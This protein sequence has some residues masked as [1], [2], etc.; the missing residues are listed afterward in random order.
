MYTVYVACSDEYRVPLVGAIQAQPNVIL[1]GQASDGQTAYDHCAR[2]QPGVLILDDA[3]LIQAS[4]ELMTQF[5][6]A[7]YPIVVLAHTEGPQTAKTA[8][9]V[10]ADDFLDKANWKSE[11]FG[12]LDRVA[13][14]LFD[15]NKAGKLISIFSSKGGVGKTTLSVNLALALAQKLHDPVV[16]VDLDLNAGDV[17]AMVGHPHPSHTVHDLVDGPLDAPRVRLALLEVAPNLYV[18][19]APEEVQDVDDIEPHLLISLLSLLKDLFSYVVVDLAPG[20]DDVIVTTLDLSD[21]ILA[22]CTPDVVT[23]RTVAQALQLLRD[24]FHYPLAKVRLVLNRSGSKTGISSADV[25]AILNN[26]VAYEL[27]SEGIIPARAANEGIPLLLSDPRC[28][29]A[30]AI[31]NLATTLIRESEATRTRRRNPTRT[32]WLGRLRNKHPKHPQPE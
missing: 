20:Y 18:L 5:A 29:L 25:K 6:Q 30:G 2:I 31:L 17:A 9:A 1:A 15:E 19:A 7:P 10:G 12:T 14:R 24:G 13:E 22:V 3:L 23:L 32:S 16:L 27:P 21:L 8:L 4:R 28:A 26:R 11:L